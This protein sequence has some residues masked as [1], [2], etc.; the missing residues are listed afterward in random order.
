MEEQ[1][2][3][4]PN[5]FAGAVSLSFDDGL[6][7]QLDNALPPLD[8]ADL[9][10][11]FYVN[12]GHRP[13]WEAQLPRWQAASQNG[14]EIGNHTARHPC[15]C[16]FGFH[17]SF[18][19]EKLSLDDMAAT[20]DAAEADLNRL[21]PEAGNQRSFC[22]PCYQSYVGAGAQRQ[23][24]VP[25]VAERFMVGRGGGERPNNPALIDLAY[26]WSW[27]LEGHSAEQMIAYIEQAVS[28]GHWA[29][30]CMHGVGA[31]H[32]AVSTEALAT[33]I[34]FLNRERRRIWTDTVV[35]IG[36]YIHCQRQ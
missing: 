25:L 10:G 29:I 15:S 8:D 5:G 31:E 11:T 6:E 4:W 22:Y 26:T 2:A 36:D 28:Q 18:C 24:Y 17:T 34:D 33:T 3:F 9:K 23:S 19:L 14:H 35:R 30:L 16:N 27:A 13:Q 12:P 20:I 1:T 7:S 21:F 32:I